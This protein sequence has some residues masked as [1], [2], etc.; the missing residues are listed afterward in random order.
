MCGEPELENGDIETNGTHYEGHE[1]NA[2]C[3]TGY[4]MVGSSWHVCESDGSWSGQD[5][6][7]KRRILFLKFFYS[8]IE[9]QNSNTN[10]LP[11]DKKSTMLCSNSL[12]TNQLQWKFHNFRGHHPD[13]GQ[14]ISSLQL[15]SAG[16]SSSQD[17]FSIFTQNISSGEGEYIVQI[18]HRFQHARSAWRRFGALQVTTNTEIEVNTAW[19]CYIFSLHEMSVNRCAQNEVLKCGSHGGAQIPF[20]LCFKNGP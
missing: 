14:W 18:W 20:N 1:W 4:V 8:S 16:S 6:E 10:T 13:R 7:C 11:I 12:H 9:I 5:T 15:L 17:S 3:H 19:G 2:T